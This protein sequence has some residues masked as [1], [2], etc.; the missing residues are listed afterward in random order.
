MHTL[1]YCKSQ[2]PFASCC[3]PYLQKKQIPL[4]ALE[5]MRS[6]YSA[7]YIGDVHYLEHTTYQHTWKEEELS[8][9]QAWAENSFWQHLEILQSDETMVE[10]KAY[11]IYEGR[12]HL[13]HEKSTFCQE[14]EEW[15]YVEGEIYE[16]KVA[17]S[18]NEK[19]ICGSDDKYKRCC[20]K[21]LGTIAKN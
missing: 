13:H 15:K 7:Y 12:Q 2:Q 8:F 21:R 9:I 17:F 3:E 10:F 1:C 19:C 16:D 5:L 20:A 6:R 14:D 18:R 4:S 11:Y